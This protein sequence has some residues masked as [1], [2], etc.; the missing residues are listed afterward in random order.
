M[1]ENIASYYDDLTPYYKLIFH[2][3]ESSVQRHGEILDS[4]IRD[5]GSEQARTVLD[6]ACGIGTQSLGLAQ[7]GYQVTASDISPVEIAMA[8]DEAE[9]RGIS[10]DYQVADMRQ[11]W[12]TFQRQFDV[13]LSFG[14]AIPHL[15]TDEDILQAFLQFYQ[16]TVHGGCCIISVRDYTIMERSGQRIFPRQVHNT[17]AGRDLLFDLWQ[18][19]GDYYDFTTYVV[20]D[21]GT[22]EAITHVMRNGRYY[23][24]T[25]ETLTTLF[26][27]AGFIDVI[28]DRERFFQP[29]LI[30]RKCNEEID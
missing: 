5:N 26:H 11:V 13:V 16:C 19:D 10:I 17:T 30:A 12:T 14:N 28:V 9:K 1:S 8:R 7:R 29:V 6:V 25:I 22:A 23:C 21:T 15:L 3:W 24:V 18:F 4:I 2:D 20:E 27:E